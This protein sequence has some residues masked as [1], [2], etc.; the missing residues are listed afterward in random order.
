VLLQHFWLGLSKESTLQLDISARGSFTHKITAEGEALLECIL[1]NTSFTET[2]PAAK[3]SSHEEVLL[4]DST[5]PSPTPIE[6]TTEPS[7]ELETTDGEEI[8]PLEFPFNIEED[9]FQ[10]FGNTSMYARE[11]RPPVP[12][13]PITPPDKASLQE[14][15]KGVTDVMNSEWVHEGRCHTKQ[16]KFKPPCTPFPISSKEL[17]SQFSIAPRSEQISCQHLLHLAI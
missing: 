13:D 11:K 14:A 17:L 10:N 3:S 4:D 1:E 16:F 5:S 2:L 8:Q 15:V 12:R 9:V 6:P 7:P